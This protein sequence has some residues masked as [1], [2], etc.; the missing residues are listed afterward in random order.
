MKLVKLFIKL[1]ALGILLVVL[2]VTSFVIYL[3]NTGNELISEETKLSLINS[4]KDTQPIPNNFQEAYNTLYTN[5]LEDNFWGYVIDRI[6]YT[7]SKQKCPCKELASTLE[8]NSPVNQPEYI[9]VLQIALQIEDY[10]TQKECLKLIINRLDF[11]YDVRGIRSASE[12]YFNK[13]IEDLNTA[14]LAGIFALMKNPAFYNPKKHPD[15]F[16]RKKHF[17]RLELESNQ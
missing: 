10:L 5:S 13:K 7:D 17:I 16:E 12:Y 1:L 11:L 6:L 4:A 15:F 8:T 3:E 14:E 2:G 9:A